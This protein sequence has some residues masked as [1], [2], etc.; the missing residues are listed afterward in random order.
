MNDSKINN[1]LEENDLNNSNFKKMQIVV[2][3]SD[4]KISN[5]SDFNKENTN[6]NYKTLNQE[7]DQIISEKIT[8]IKQFPQLVSLEEI[9][10]IEIYKHIYDNHY[11]H[12]GYRQSHNC[13]DLT[14]SL[15]ECHNET[16]NIWTHL[17][18]ACLLLILLITT[19]EM[20]ILDN[21]S[22]MLKFLDNQ[23]LDKLLK[24][25]YYIKN[26][27]LKNYYGENN[28][29]LNSLEKNNHLNLKYYNESFKEFEEFY[30]K[31][32]SNRKRE[33]NF[34]SSPMLNLYDSNNLNEF[35]L[36]ND[37]FLFIFIF[38]GN[39]NLH[40]YNEFNEFENIIETRGVQILRILQKKVKISNWTR[41]HLIFTDALSFEYGTMY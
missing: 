11:I 6:K 21:E 4:E 16:T 10:K 17:L 38:N 35:E 27:K 13:E 15:C 23:D 32:M 22:Y 33:H 9:R 2:K 8:D 7:Q 5:K 26:G 20:D 24:N 41:S 19:Y 37:E 29:N 14:R 1:N 40:T 25:S 12:T 36:K 39:L 34:T 18:G 28:S 3:S 30:N 31:K